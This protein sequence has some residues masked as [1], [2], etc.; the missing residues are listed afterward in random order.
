MAGGHA[1]QGMW[2]GG[3]AWQGDM[4]G[5][6]ACMAGAHAWQGAHPLPPANTTRYGQ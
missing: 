4:C 5:W 3:R 1:W 6:G 2:Q